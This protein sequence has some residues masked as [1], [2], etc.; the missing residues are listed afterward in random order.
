[1]QKDLKIG[2]ALGLVLVVV[3]ALWLS[4]RP[5]LSTKARMLGSREA[6]SLHSH[7]TEPQ[8]ESTEQTRSAPN[9]PNTSSTNTTTEIKAEQSN[10]PDLIVHE[11]RATNKQQDMKFHIV[12][13]GETLY[14]I[15][16]KYY[17]SAN[18]W[19]KICDA[20]RKTIKDV[21]RLAPGAKLIIPD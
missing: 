20:N 7:N 11:Q 9:L 13:K 17:G 10:V 18:K 4:T 1:M 6:T 21:N 3:A 8:Q 16:H 2:M 19:Q 15:S 12:R 14:D 5:S